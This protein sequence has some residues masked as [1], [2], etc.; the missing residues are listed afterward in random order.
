ME[1]KEYIVQDGDIMH[2]VL[3][4]KCVKY[5]FETINLFNVIIKRVYC[6]LKRQKADGYKNKRQSRLTTYLLTL[7]S[8]TMKNH[9]TK[10]PF[11]G[12]EKKYW[13]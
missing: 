12:F 3:M 2:F 13:D 1:G 8:N 4:C 6:F 10:Y 11:D 9:I 5:S 7:K